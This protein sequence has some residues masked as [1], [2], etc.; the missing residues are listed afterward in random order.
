MELKSFLSGVKTIAIVGLSDNP[1]RPSYSVAEYMIEQGFD[2][3]P[4]NPTIKEVFGKKSYASLADVP[5]EIKIDLVD[6]FRKSEEVFP[7]VKSA[8]ELGI[9]RI[10]MQEGVKNEDAIV[11]AQKHGAEV[12]A[13]VCLMKSMK[14]PAQT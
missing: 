9:M 13:D 6:I 5:A 2:I 11:Y 8:I 12:I 3:I 14:Y 7:I 4:I 1:T 10:W